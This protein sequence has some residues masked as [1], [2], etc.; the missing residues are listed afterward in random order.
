MMYQIRLEIESETFA[1]EGSD[2][3][4]SNAW[5]MAGMFMIWATGCRLAFG[6]GSYYNDDTVANSFRN[7]PGIVQARKDYYAT[8]KS[9]GSATFGA[10][11]YWNAKNDPIETFVGTYDYQISV[12]N[13]SLQ[14]T[15]T[16]RTSISSL[17]PHPQ[18]SYIWP[19]SWNPTSGPFSNFYQTY[20]FTEPIRK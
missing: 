19:E 4:S 2:S 6:A 8:G 18:G 16:N 14:F 20:I 10:S 3:W 12:I 9:N 17:I 11:G 15:I 1:K 7:A 5:T 13:N